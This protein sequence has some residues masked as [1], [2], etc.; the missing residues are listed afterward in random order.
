M[1]KINFIN[2]RLVLILLFL[3]SLIFIILVKIISVQVKDGLFLQSEGE[4][5]Q[6]TFNKTLPT[7]GGI[8]DRNS[9][10]LAITVTN[11]DLYALKGFS[12]KQFAKLSNIIEIESYTNTS[13]SKKT[14]LVSDLTLS[15]VNAIK[16]LSINNIEIESRQSRH[17]PLGQQIAP[18]IG[19]YGKD[20]ALEGLEKSYDHILSGMSGKQKLYRNAKQEVISKPIV[21]KKTVHGQDI[22]LTIDATIQ[23]YAYKHLVEAVKNNKAKA[24]TAIILDNSK[25][26]VL[27]MVSY[28]SYNPNNPARKVQKNRALV[29][30]YEL[31]SVMKPI[32]FSGILENN[33]LQADEI[34]ETPQRIKIGNKVISDTKNHEKLSIKEIIAHSSQVGASKLAISLGYNELKRTYLNFGFTKPISLNFPSSAFGFMNFSDGIPQHSLA[35]L[36][37]GYGIKVSPYQLSTAYSV[38]A[39][40]GILKD[41][42]LLL[43]DEIS[44]KRIISNQ[45][46]NQTIDALKEVIKIGTGKKA[47]IKGYEVAGKTGTAHKIRNGDYA[48]DLYQ[49]SFV[50]ITPLSKNSLTIFVSID[51][52]GLN[53]YSGGTIAAPLFKVIAEDVL[54]YLGYIGNE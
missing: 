12:E 13:F 30:S 7:R 29:D 15:E 8:Y 25:G 9:F 26:E 50:G 20:G 24:G 52:P 19:F 4:K 27:A 39:N 46:A 3:I 41:F 23:F 43:S 45:T 17:Y 42:K 47:Y 10:P 49:A 38:F 18:L 21:I 54:N 22:A 14:L 2:W 36:G 48:D 6:I 1:N 44:S 11:Y 31:G 28:P 5:R 16:K 32:V 35:S 40:D 33:L 37:Y 53:A 51:E 34:I